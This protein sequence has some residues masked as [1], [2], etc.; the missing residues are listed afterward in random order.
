MSVGERLFT[1]QELP[2]DGSV[3]ER[4]VWTA[5]TKP[6][7]GQSGGARSCPIQPWPLGGTQRTV[8]T[9]YPGAR[10]PSEQIL[11]PKQKN[12]KLSG[13][14]FD[15]WNRY[16][17]FTAGGF[18]VAEMRRFDAMCQRGNPCQFQF[19][20]IVRVGIIV[21]WDFPYQHEARIGY[22]FDVSV[23]DDPTIPKPLDR[24]P[25]TVD[26]PSSSFD[27]TDAAVQASLAALSGMPA[28][29]MSGTLADDTNASMTSLTGARES[30]GATLDNR[31]LD[32]PAKPSDSFTRL[33]TQFRAVRAA[34][35]DT[36]VALAS[37]RADSALS[38]FT[39]ISVLNFE[40]WS[41]S[42]RFMCRIVMNNAREGDLA[43][44]KRATPDAKRLYRPSAGES[45]YAISSKFYG[46]PNA[47]GLIYQRNSLSS[48]N[49]LGNEILIIPER[50]SA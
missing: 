7:T 41:R 38:V 20:S 11:G 2:S 10:R 22:A 5:S 48:F 8:R 4:F 45:L 28:T 31:E 43:A 21:D 30:L 12:F 24:S 26:S 46:T 39:A 42:T 18:A 32:P 15:K 1:I 17:D 47:W 13:T 27:K 29:A 50:G 49:L 36:V 35:Y 25:V 9:D 34:A 14:W 19:L 40:D 16:G 6:A 23:H 33:A 37:V 44:T 3:G